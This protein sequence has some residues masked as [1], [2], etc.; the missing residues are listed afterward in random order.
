MDYNLT[1][2][3]ETLLRV[4]A[5]ALEALDL[6]AGRKDIGLGEMLTEVCLET[7]QQLAGEGLIM[8][9]NPFYDPK[10]GA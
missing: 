2:R 9:F 6:L 10:K 8:D 7:S 4:Q 5:K 3:Q 1:D